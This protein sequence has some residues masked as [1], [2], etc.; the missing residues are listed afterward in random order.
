VPDAARKVEVGDTA[1]TLGLLSHAY[2][3]PVIIEGVKAHGVGATYPVGQMDTW[4]KILP[5]YADFRVSQHVMSLL[6]R[7]DDLTRRGVA[8]GRF[9][10]SYLKVLEEWAFQAERRIFSKLQVRPE[11]INDNNPSIPRWERY[12]RRL[13]I[14]DAEKDIFANISQVYQAS[15][16]AGTDVLKFTRG[17][18]DSWWG[19]YVKDLYAAQRGIAY[20]QTKEERCNKAV[21]I[22]RA[23]AFFAKI[24]S[25]SFF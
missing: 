7:F 9:T 3:P 2:I 23:I 21:G 1:I 6:D 20:E 16:K 12:L 13:Y 18:L 14:N 22:E 15:E 5:A 4:E 17:F 11:D 10:Q 25:R 24:D 8:T 19:K